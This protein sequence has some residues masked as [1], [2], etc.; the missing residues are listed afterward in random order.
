MR[1][2]ASYAG[3][4][5]G[6]LASSYREYNAGLAHGTAYTDTVQSSGDALADKLSRHAETLLAG[7]LDDTYLGSL[8]EAVDFEHRTIF[9]S[10]AHT[11]LM[12][13]TLRL[14]L[15]EVGRRN[16]FSGP[17]AAAEA[18]KLVELLRLD[19]N[20]SIGG[21]QTMRQRDA[22][23]REA[24]VDRQ[25]DAFR[26]GMKAMSARLLD[27]A[28]IVKQATTAFNGAM[29]AA[30]VETSRAEIAWRSLLDTASDSA[31]ATEKLKS[32]ALTISHL[33]ADGAA[34][35]A[36]SSGTARTA[37]E[38]AAGFQERIGGIK[39]I[40]ETIGA[41]AS[42]TNL[43]AL[44]ATIEAARAGEAGR[45][46]AVVATEV[47]SL[48][49][50][51]TQATGDISEQI[52]RAI[53]DSRQLYDPISRLAQSLSGL[54][55]VA[56]KIAE[57]ANGQIQATEEV[58][59]QADVTTRAIDDAIRSSDGSRQAASAVEAAAGSLSQGAA[60]IERLAHSLHADVR[61]FLDKLRQHA[62]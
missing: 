24:A 53:A 15:P 8:R 22:E 45:G 59:R 54:G 35:G 57:S 52:A 34:L 3:T 9:G 2:A 1:I 5:S 12:M 10:R 48:A 40:V 42:Q 60:D 56:G 41:I 33:A 21:V 29:A 36:D 20:L 7:R 46:F 4:L 11:V 55:E 32:A 31:A 61:A 17:S 39:S 18:L 44:N 28:G 62:A 47:K 27:V 25:T 43:L 16:R 6:A 49:S 50:Q 23:E 51:V 30:Q 13:L 14:L 26:E 19:L 37:S 38:L 58:S